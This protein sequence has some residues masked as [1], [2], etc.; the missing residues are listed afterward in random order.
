MLPRKL[1]Q[2]LR[3]PSRILLGA[4]CIAL[5]MFGSILSVAH[6][7][8]DGGASHADCGLCVVAHMSVEATTAPVQI[9]VVYV[10]AEIEP[11]IP[12]SR[13]QPAPEFA[14]FSRPPPA[15]SDRS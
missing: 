12:V 10:F 6:T 15:A 1:H 4:L 11:S 8:T 5:V 13:P 7:H 14:L 9:P 2:E 3:S